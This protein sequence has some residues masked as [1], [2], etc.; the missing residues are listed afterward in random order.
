MSKSS[1]LQKLEKAHKE[2]IAVKWEGTLADYIGILEK[3]PE[4]EMIAH[5]RVLKMI[6]SY[7]V[8]R[9]EENN[10]ISYSFDQSRIGTENAGGVHYEKAMKKEA[11]IYE[12]PL[13][14]SS[15]IFWEL[16]KTLFFSMVLATLKRLSS[17]L[18]L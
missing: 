11:D 12:L 5:K 2:D 6:E 15:L 18:C 7:G 4:I 10:I 3:N 14:S 1:L 16:K 9:D 13:A 17:V 8:E